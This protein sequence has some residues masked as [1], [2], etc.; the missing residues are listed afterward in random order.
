MFFRYFN[1]LGVFWTKLEKSGEIRAKEGKYLI[2]ENQG[3]KCNSGGIIAY[4]VIK[5]EFRGALCNLPKIKAGSEGGNM[6]AFPKVSS[7]RIARRVRAV[8][9]CGGKEASEGKAGSHGGNK[10]AFQ[11]A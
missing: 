2:M 1:S 10:P 8:S 9:S 3:S 4:L 6:P 5:E 11:K 7:R